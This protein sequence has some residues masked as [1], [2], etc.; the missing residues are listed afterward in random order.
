MRQVHFVA[1]LQAQN[2]TTLPASWRH[3]DARTDTYSPE[4]YQHIARV[5]EDGPR[6]E[7]MTL[8]YMLTPRYATPEQVTGGAFTVAS[9]IYQLGLIL[10]R[11]LTGT[12]AQPYFRIFNPTSQGERW[13][14]DGEYVRRWI[15]ELRGLA[16]K[17]VHRP[18]ETPML[19]GGYPAPILDHA[20]RRAEALRRFGAVRRPAS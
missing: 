5:L 15:P 2:C 3:P 16:G 4:Y 8:E 18:W 20:E 7:G 11:M 12:D 6:T 17:K 13:D 10:Y 1:F 14:P 19:A 9:D